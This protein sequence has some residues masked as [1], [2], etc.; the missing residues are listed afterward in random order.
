MAEYY[1]ALLYNFIY[2]FTQITI[3]NLPYGGKKN[4]LKRALCCMSLFLTNFSLVLQQSV[5]SPR[6]Q[7]KT[8]SHTDQLSAVMLLLVS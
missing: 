3:V 4:L 8:A 6:P 2:A 5:T 1:F 7:N